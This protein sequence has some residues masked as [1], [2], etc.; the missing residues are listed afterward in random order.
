VPEASLRIELFSPDLDALLAFYVDVL[1]FTA[2]RDERHNAVPYLGL[3]RGA[4]HIGV[5]RGWAPTDPELRFPP[6]GV[7][8]VLEVDDL[9]D[10]RAAIRAAGWELS[11]TSSSGP[12]GYT[13][14]DCGTPPATSYA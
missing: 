3:R 11:R 13:T 9:D 6:Q 4:V 5:V 10:E 2:I 8:L 1:R 7:E 14:S 12:G